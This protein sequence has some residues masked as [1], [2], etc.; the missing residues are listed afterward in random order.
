MD[1]A[2]KMFYIDHMVIQIHIDIVAV[3]LKRFHL[4][5]SQNMLQ[6]IPSPGTVLVAIDYHSGQSVDQAPDVFFLAASLTPYPAPGLITVYNGVLLQTTIFKITNQT[7]E[8]SGAFLQPVGQA[9]TAQMHRFTRQ[10]VHFTIK[11]GIKNIFVESKISKERTRSVRSRNNVN[12][13]RLTHEREI[14]FVNFPVQSF[15]ADNL[16]IMLHK[17]AYLLIG[18]FTETFDD[19][20]TCGQM[21][22][23]T[24]MTN[25]TA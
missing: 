3:R 1:H 20:G 23:I 19:D 5:V 13:F 14:A 22:D 11:R 21:A 17:T 4:A 25:R 7:A 16:V 15:I 6:G 24:V 9:H 10:S 2:T 12:D 18:I 8:M